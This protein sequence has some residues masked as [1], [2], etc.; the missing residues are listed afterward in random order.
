MRAAK[1]RIRKEER[2]RE[3][4][5]NNV[6]CMNSD[7]ERKGEKQISDWYNDV[8]KRRNGINV[9]KKRLTREVKGK[10]EHRK[11]QHSKEVNSSNCQRRRLS[12]LY[13][14]VSVFVCELWAWSLMW[15]VCVCLMIARVG[16]QNKSTKTIAFE[17]EE[18]KKICRVCWGCP[19]QGQIWRYIDALLLLKHIRDLWFIHTQ[20]T[21]IVILPST[22]DDDGF[23]CANATP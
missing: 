13:L 23:L 2:D 12:C 5:F 9:N 17:V 3:R 4:Y 10:K 1:H 21:T 6:N 16:E 20:K 19:V 14:Y 22:L 18:D 7:R 8:T 11:A 15:I